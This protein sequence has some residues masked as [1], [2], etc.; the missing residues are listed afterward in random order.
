L[1]K[2]YQSAKGKQ[3]DWVVS[4]KERNKKYPLIKQIFLRMEDEYDI[5]NGS[6][7]YLLQMDRCIEII[8]EIE[9]DKKGTNDEKH[10][11][12]TEKYK[13]ALLYLDMLDNIQK[14]SHLD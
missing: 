1:K 9:A 14:Y 13:Y 4:K 8:D 5:D 12:M 2:L 10:L 11:N 3:N 7:P 6:S